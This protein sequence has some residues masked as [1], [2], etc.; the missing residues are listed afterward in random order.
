[1]QSRCRASTEQEQSRSR[2]GAEQVHRTGHRRAQ[3]QCVDSSTRAA[4]PVWVEVQHAHAWEARAAADVE[5]ATERGTGGRVAIGRCWRVLVRVPEAEQ[6]GRRGHLELRV[7]KKVA[8][9]AASQGGLAS[10]KLSDEEEDV[11]SLSD[12]GELSSEALGGL[13]VLEIKL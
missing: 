11:A 6:V 12:G 8:Q 10:A 1:V 3:A 5:R 4:S 9:E 13:N 7:G 2:A